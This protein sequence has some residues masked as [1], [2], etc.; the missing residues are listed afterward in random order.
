MK[1]TRQ[2]TRPL[3][4]PHANARDTSRLHSLS[5][6][7][8]PIRA[9]VSRAAISHNLA[10]ACAKAPKAKVWAVVK[11][12]AYGHGLERVLPALSKADGIALLDL[13]EATRA[14]A[15]GYRLPILLLEGFFEAA[16]LALVDHLRLTATV[17]SHRQLEMLE[18]ARLKAPID[19]YLK[20]NSGMN[21]LGFRPADAK[22]VYQRLS[23]LGNVAGITLMTHFANADLA[24]GAVS[25]TSAFRHATDGLAG[26]RSLSNSAAVLMHPEAH[27]EWIRPGIMLY[28]ASPTDVRDAKSF[29]LMPAMTLSSELIAVQDIDA[30]Q[31]VGYG[32]RFVARRPTRIGVVACGYADGYPRIADDGCPVLV[33][34]RIAPLSGRVSMDMLTVDITDLPDAA[35]GTPVELWGP[36]LSVDQVA[37]FGKTSGYELLCAL[38]PRV[39][40]IGVD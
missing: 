7:P 31:S 11:A 1:A 28:G 26:P 13:D 19:I 9:L 10:L 3:Q 22:E 34:D 39:P 21:R 4:W 29:G 32:G 18:G 33:G 23:R 5:I 16:D 37:A 40:V 2:D 17:H 8:R 30:G 14:R 20:I 12:N 35:V 36:R 24:D 25:V 38:A 15:S 27:G 6:M